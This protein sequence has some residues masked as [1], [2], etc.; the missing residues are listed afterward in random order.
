M[1]PAGTSDWLEVEDGTV[2]EIPH[3]CCAFIIAP[4]L[5]PSPKTGR[6]EALEDGGSCLL[7]PGWWKNSLSTL[8]LHHVLAIKTHTGAVLL[9]LQP[10]P[11]SLGGKG[12]IP[13][14]RCCPRR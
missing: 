12:L 2:S 1:E 6:V 5:L 11:W 7:L 9:S 13:S 8:V 3:R 4:I 14:F 10:G